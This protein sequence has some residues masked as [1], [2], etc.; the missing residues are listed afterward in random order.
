[1]RLVLGQYRQVEE[2]AKAFKDFEAM[3]ANEFSSLNSY[4]NAANA[5]LKDSRKQLYFDENKGRLVFSFL[6]SD[7]RRVSEKRKSNISLPASNKSSRYSPSLP[8][9]LGKTVCL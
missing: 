7:N 4:I 3:S 2:L 5:F 8:F 1:M 9:L 6:D